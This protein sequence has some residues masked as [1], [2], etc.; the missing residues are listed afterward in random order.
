[1]GQSFLIEDDDGAPYPVCALCPDQIALINGKHWVH[2]YGNV[3]G[4]RWC[5]HRCQRPHSG[6]YGCDATPPPGLA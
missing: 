5:L 4:D 3:D 6:V 2:I 1:M